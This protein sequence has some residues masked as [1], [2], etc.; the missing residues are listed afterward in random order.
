LKDAIEKFAS[1][2][3]AQRV[4]IKATTVKMDSL[5]KDSTEYKQ[6][7]G[8]RAKLLASLYETINAAVEYGHS[9]IV[10][11]LGGHQ[12]LVNGL[13]G[14]LID[15]NKAGDMKGQLPRAVFK[16][17]AKFQTMSDELLQKLKF[18]KLRSRWERL[19]DED[20][21]KDIATI[22]A[23][24]TN[25]KKRATDAKQDG[26]ADKEKSLKEKVDQANSRA[27]ETNSP[28]PANPAKRPHEGDDSDTKPN[29]KIA[30]EVSGTN[31]SSSKLP[32]IRKA[33]SNLLGISSKPVA[34]SAPKKR[35]VSPPLV[36]KLGA[37]LASI[38]K[39]REVRKVAEAPPRPPETP[40]EKARRERKE[41]RRHLRVRFKEGAEL[42]EI[43]LFKH[44]RAE[45]EGRQDEMLKDAHEHR[46]EGMMH[47]KQSQAS[48]LIENEDEDEYEPSEADIPY[49]VTPI[50][51]TNKPTNFGEIYVTR[52]GSRT[53]TTLEQEIQ[54]KREGAELM[55]IYT[56][57][58]EIPPTP[59][60]F[61]FANSSEM[62]G[63]DDYEPEPL[64]KT[65]TEPWLVQRLHEI[66][67]YGP[68]VARHVFAHTQPARQIDQDAAHPRLP[69]TISAAFPP[70]FGAPFQQGHQ[71][72]LPPSDPFAFLQSIVK[73]L[74]GKPYPP[75]E[76]P[77]WMTD[78]AKRDEWMAGY[79]R[80]NPVKVQAEVPQ[81]MAQMQATN[82]IQPPHFAPQHL[83][84]QPPQMTFPLPVQQPGIPVNSNNTQMPNPADLQ[85]YLAGVQIGDRAGQADY[86][87]W[88][89]N[90]KTSN[91][92]NGYA[93]QSQPRW[94][95]NWNT[96]N[97]KAGRSYDKKPRGGH[98]QKSVGNNNPVLFD[99][100]GEYKGKKRPCRFYQEGK[101]AKGAAC[102]YLH[103]D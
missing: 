6:L 102:T 32:P 2:F 77:E 44:E 48:K 14:T 84:Q 59:K 18:D 1:F 40:E 30:S 42:E 15:C 50:Q 23:N 5:A 74:K 103:D 87:S 47:K 96:D 86:G 64:V 81:R 21:T 85:A 34:R 66:Q 16:L 29:K 98:N 70:Q 3:M 53:F 26:E 12:K 51:V 31:S 72:Q 75:T 8:V 45:D 95:G 33:A 9:R 68:E 99:E 20:I 82:T 93:N 90:T 49:Q 91:E 73:S 54:R 38:E 78:Q 94:E 61:T 56:T 25:A 4:Q 79:M 28:Q 71:S 55:V 7:E 10:Q 43:K 67:Q 62:E 27:Y 83:A 46:L 60:E 35:E 36:S 92:S 58:D 89:G 39:P 37:I 101:C 76:P 41:S 65:P 24:T 57:P 17:L 88:T 100:R 11:N 69:P 63:A 80:D 52:G 19:G 22:L 97:T 13:T